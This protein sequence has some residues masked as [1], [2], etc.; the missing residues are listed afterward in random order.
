LKGKIEKTFQIK[1]LIEKK[2]K[3]QEN[4]DQVLKK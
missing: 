4:D 2:N 3:N 1:K